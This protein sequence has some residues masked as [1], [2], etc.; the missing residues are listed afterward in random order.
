MNALS[1]RSCGR[2]CTRVCAHCQGSPAF[3]AA[4]RRRNLTARRM[5][6]SQSHCMQSSAAAEQQVLDAIASVTGRGKDGIN[7]E[8]QAAFDKAIQAL[9]RDGGVAEPTSRPDVL[10]GRCVRLF[11]PLCMDVSR[12]F[13]STATPATRG[14]F[15]RTQLCSIGAGGSYCTQADLRQPRRYSAHSRAQRVSRSSRKYA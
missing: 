11:R 7:N 4:L 6:T 15:G 14:D 8:Q 3:S 10:D 2:C 5:L 1:A 9:E 12:L 13:S